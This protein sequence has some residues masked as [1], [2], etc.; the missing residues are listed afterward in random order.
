MPLSGSSGSQHQRSTYDVAA[1]AGVLRGGASELFEDTSWATRFAN[2]SLGPSHLDDML[3]QA[4]DAA[5]VDV[6]TSSRR[7]AIEAVCSLPTVTSALLTVTAECHV[8][9]LQAFRFVLA[10]S[11]RGLCTT[12]HQPSGCGAKGASLFFRRFQ[13]GSSNQSTCPQEDCLVHG[14]WHCAR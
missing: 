5:L 10:R 6:R 13:H 1:D 4:V 14:P 3:M 9:C 7:L 2:V 12:R 8:E 11:A